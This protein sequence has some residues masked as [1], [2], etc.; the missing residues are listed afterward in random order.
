MKKSLALTVGGAALAASLLLAGCSSTAGAPSGDKAPVAANSTPKATPKSTTAKFGGVYKYDDG[1]TVSVA[2]PAS[3]TPGQ[4]AAGATQAHN[5]ILAFTIT[6]G[7]TKNL[8]P[9]SL[10]KVSSAGVE[11]TNV[12]D[13]TEQTWSL[14]RRR[15]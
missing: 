10:P 7:S 13:M 3:F 4:Y 11:A 12:I 9:V 2:A 1:V 6:N 5:V 15:P 14:S 8:N